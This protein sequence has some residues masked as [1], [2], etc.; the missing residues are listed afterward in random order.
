MDTTLLRG[1]ANDGLIDDNERK[2]IDQQVQMPLSVYW[3][4]EVKL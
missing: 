2:K 4:G 3:E 1:L